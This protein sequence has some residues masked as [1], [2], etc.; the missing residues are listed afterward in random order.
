MKRQIFINEASFFASIPMVAIMGALS[1]AA[2][3][4]S[5]SG[6]AC[7]LLFIMSLSAAS[8]GYN[9]LTL[10]G[11]QVD[12]AFTGRVYV[13]GETVHLK[14][15]IK[16]NGNLPVL[17]GKIRIPVLKFSPIDASGC[18]GY[19]ALSNEEVSKSRLYGESLSGVLEAEVDYLG[20]GE[21]AECTFDIKAKERGV[22]NLGDALVYCSDIT[23]LS[24]EGKNVQTSK[25]ILICPRIINVSTNRFLQDMMLG[26]TGLK[27]DMDD[28]TLIK[29]NRPYQYS[30]PVKSI[31][32]HLLA[33]GAGL[34]VNRYDKMSNKSIHFIIDGESFNAKYLDKRIIERVLSVVFSEITELQ[35]RGMGCG[36]S[37]PE[38]NSAEAVNIFYRGRST[39]NVIGEHLAKY[40]M[41]KYEVEDTKPVIFQKHSSMSSTIIKAREQK[42]EREGI[43]KSVSQ[44]NAEELIRQESNIGVCFYFTYDVEKMADNMILKSM[45]SKGKLRVVTYKPYELS[46]RYVHEEKR[47]INF[48]SITEGR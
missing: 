44:F 24:S 30:D 25:E 41:K 48:V 1:I 37:L 2:M 17:K 23:G 15:S 36:L 16:N 47:I 27:S 13:K 46:G 20:K 43:Q 6:I 42:E 35:K 45:N 7:I 19:R 26:D 29:Q 8:C 9:R 39:I 22:W 14:C 32:W 21:T 33:K 34:F 11:I 28:M 3:Y 4:C 12:F 38:Q 10:R 18:D 31:N 5:M 40:H